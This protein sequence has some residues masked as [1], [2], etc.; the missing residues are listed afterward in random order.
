MATNGE[1]RHSVFILCSLNYDLNTF[2]SV[3]IFYTSGW[4]WYTF[5]ASMR[6]HFLFIL[7]WT[8]RTFWN[9]PQMVH[10]LLCTMVDFKFHPDFFPTYVFRKIHIFS[11]VPSSLSKW[12]IHIS[13]MIAPKS[14]KSTI[15][16]CQLSDRHYDNPWQ[17]GPLDKE[18]RSQ[19]LFFLQPCW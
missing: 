1:N 7:E 8:I 17:Q 3:T 9:C 18:L 5:N 13:R 16:T 2:C 14:I 15:L 6:F 11:R 12:K 4:W 19:L 10:L